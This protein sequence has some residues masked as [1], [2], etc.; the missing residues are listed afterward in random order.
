MLEWD[1]GEPGSE[2]KLGSSEG[3]GGSEAV[4]LTRAGL[5][6]CVAKAAHALEREA[7]ALVTDPSTSNRSQTQGIQDQSTQVQLYLAGCNL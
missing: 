5:P 1:V 7:G 6:R 2:G 4:H 3:L